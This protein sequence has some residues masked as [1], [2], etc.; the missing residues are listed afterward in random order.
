MMTRQATDQLYIDLG[1][2][3]PEEYFTYEANA[4]LNSVAESTLTATVGVIREN[5][6][7]LEVTVSITATISHIEG[8]DLFAFTEAA[9]AAQVDRI[10]D[11]NIQTSSQ[12]DLAADYV[13]IVQ[14]DSFESAIFTVDVIN[15]RGRAFNI[16]TQAAF[17][18]DIT[19]D[20]IVQSSLAIDSQFTQQSDINTIR[21]TSADFQAFTT[22]LTAVVKKVDELADLVSVFECTATVNAVRDNT[23]STNANTELT[24]Q[25]TKVKQAQAQTTATSQLVWQGQLVTRYVGNP[26]VT[27]GGTYG[28]LAFTS[29]SRWGSAVVSTVPNSSA[30]RG[31]IKFPDS[32]E[33]TN[34]STVDFWVKITSL[35][36]P[37]PI[38]G[39]VSDPLNWVI[40]ETSWNLYVTGAKLALLARDATNTN[41][42][43]YA[44]SNL[45]LNQY[46]HVRVVKTSNTLA[47]FINGVRTNLFTNFIPNKDTARPLSIGD[48]WTSSSGGAT[49][50]LYL[51]E[52][53]ISKTVLTD[54]SATTYAVPTKP[55]V[56]NSN[57]SL[58]LHL[59]NSYADDN[60][61]APKIRIAQAELNATTALAAIAQR[62]I[63]PISANLS[64]ISALICTA[65]EQPEDAQANLYVSTELFAFADKIKPGLIELNVST[66]LTADS[67]RI[68]SAHAEL[69]AWTTELVA[70]ARTAEFFINCDVITDIQTNATTIARANSQ[71]STNT[72]LTVNADRSIDITADINSEVNVSI[73]SSRIRSTNAEITIDTALIVTATETNEFIANL[74]CTFVSSI[75]FEVIKNAQSELSATTELNASPMVLKTASANL[76]TTTDVLAIS[77]NLLSADAHWT[78]L[79]AQLTLI[80]VV[81]IDPY[82]T[83][84][85]EPEQR[86]Y[87]IAPEQREYIVEREVRTYIIRN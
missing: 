32:A 43:Y 10:R 19:F 15:E 60:L 52:L 73:D 57:Y 14:A 69:Q 33:W 20:K 28:T 37:I 1:Y 12:F 13:R 16:E 4:E 42:V 76:V 81:H 21:N 75:D 34:W 85:I 18:M 7:V 56:N 26:T 70:A 83:W 35:D 6:A 39:Q 72:E 74:T 29:D 54:P 50:P 5:S 87:V 30:L 40:N 8:A 59:D 23:I 9:L 86:V 53:L 2:F 65:E 79:S 55:W 84:V 22:Q 27:S 38:I 36:N 49:G 63:G 41:T 78:A 82:L 71:Q 31:N 24:S 46:N 68:Q 51:D 45:T 61:A 44:T 62:N 47:F 64:S 11:N 58:L 67:L 17:S 80:T 77:G 48:F 66:S 3:T 25:A